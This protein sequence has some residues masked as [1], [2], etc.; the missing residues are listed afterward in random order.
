M[1]DIIVHPQFQ[2]KG[3]GVMVVRTLLTEAE[4]VGLEIVTVSYEENKTNFYQAGGFTTGSGGLW[5][6]KNK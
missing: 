4:R 5:Q 1:E 3:I 2:K 6:S